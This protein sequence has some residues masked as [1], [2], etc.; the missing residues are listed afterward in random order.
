MLNVGDDTV[1]T[2][3]LTE[4]LMGDPMSRKMEGGAITCK[5]EEGASML[6]VVVGRSQGMKAT[7]VFQPLQGN[8]RLSYLPV[9]LL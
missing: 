7:W 2:R 3:T 9:Q 8:Q 6:I 5:R 4:V 1:E